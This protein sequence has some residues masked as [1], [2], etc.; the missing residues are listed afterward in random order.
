MKCLK[1]GLKIKEN[2]EG[3]K[4]YC[5]GHYYWDTL[6]NKLKDKN[7]KQEAR[8]YADTFQKR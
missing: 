5:Q 6:N 3:K 4:G 2:S 7:T 8:P 1:C